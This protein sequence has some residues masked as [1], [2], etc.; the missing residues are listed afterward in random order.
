M[1]ITL[2]KQK[3]RAFLITIRFQMKDLKQTN[4]RKK[5]LIMKLDMNLLVTSCE[6][7]HTGLLFRQPNTPSFFFFFKQRSNEMQYV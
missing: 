4:E 3:C 5:K 1:E 6:K 2:N 7:I